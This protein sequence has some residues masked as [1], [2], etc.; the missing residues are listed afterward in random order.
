MKN[1][2]KQENLKT[3]FNN[4]SP[5]LLQQYFNNKRLLN[6]VDF[7]EEKEAR[8]KNGFTNF[9]IEKIAADS[10]RAKIKADLNKIHLMRDVKAIQGFIRDGSLKEATISKIKEED[11]NFNQSFI[12]FLEEQENFEEFYLVYD[13]NKNGKKWWNTRNDYV[14]GDREITEEI[15]NNLIEEAKKDLE[16]KNQDSEFC[17]K[18]ITLGDNEYVFAFYE[19]LA[20]EQHKIKNG[21][22][23]TTF[24]NPVNKVVFLYNK[25][26]KFMK[27]YGADKF[28]KEKMHK[29]AAKVIFKKEEIP[30]EQE[31][32]EI[33]DLRRVYDDL[34]S[35]QEVSFKISPNSAIN[36]LKPSND[37][38]EIK[39]GKMKGEYNDLF[40]SLR[41]HIAI[42]EASKNEISFDEVEPLWISFVALYQDP[43]DK[44]KTAT[45]EFKITN[46]NNICN[47]GDEDIDFEILECL[48]DSGIMKI[49]EDQEPAN[50][51]DKPDDS[52][53]SQTA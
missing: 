47:I 14:S 43:F 17:S 39:S 12:L 28:I 1:S 48:Q 24:S 20:Q 21:E 42:D 33:Y 3:L 35:N 37:T 31:R 8:K 52:K 18:R 27:I 50:S 4:S 7:E 51:N 15:S 16:R 41:Q 34:V 9:L 22:L 29:V 26:N 45:K 11:S 49:R 13:V 2:F 19:D 38:L 5:S 23:E 32:N 44:N 6:D 36:L 40:D 46:K 10:E 25:T 53:H 30:Q